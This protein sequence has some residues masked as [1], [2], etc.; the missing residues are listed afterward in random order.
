MQEDPP[1][2]VRMHASI[3]GRLTQAVRDQNWFAVALELIIVVLGV[4]IGFQVTAWGQARADEAREQTYLR[5][6][7]AD[8]RET[9]RMTTALD[10]ILYEPDRAG[11]LMWAAFYATESP[12]RDSIFT[13]RSRLAIIHLARPVLA[14][15]EGLVAT[16]DL[17]LIRDDLLRSAVSTYLETSR[18]RLTEQEEQQRIWWNGLDRLDQGLDLIEAYHETIGQE[19]LESIAE[20]TSYPPLGETRFRFPLDVDSFLSDRELLSATWRMTRAKDELRDMRVQIRDDALALLGRVE[21]E[22]EQQAP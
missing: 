20:S 13:W 19:A 17:G 6:L 9:S 10:S 18:T 4:V 12:P 8:L 21:M 22:L 15:V 16:G 5:Q 7:A 3:L 11:G 14:T 2:A 1:R